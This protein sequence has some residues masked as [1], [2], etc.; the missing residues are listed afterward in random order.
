M[1][2]RTFLKAYLK[3]STNVTVIDFVNKIIFTANFNIRFHIVIKIAAKYYCCVYWT[4]YRYWLFMHVEYTLY[5][6]HLLHIHHCMPVL[7]D[8]VSL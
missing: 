1:S 2:P 7:A 4:D 6:V 3:V 8:C 5:F